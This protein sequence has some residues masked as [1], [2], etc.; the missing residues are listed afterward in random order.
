MK[1]NNPIGLL[2]LTSVQRDTFLP[3]P[4][5]GWTI[6]N[7]TNNRIES[8]DGVIWNG[9]DVH[10]TPTVVTL[11][12]LKASGGQTVL[13]GAAKIVYVFHAGETPS[14][15][16]IADAA[17]TGAWETITGADKYFSVGGDFKDKNGHT[18]T[19]TEV[20]GGDG[21]GG[22]VWVTQV[23][24]ALISLTVDTASVLMNTANAR[25]GN[26]RVATFSEGVPQDLTLTFP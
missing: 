3:T 10:I 5:I 2:H 24:Q 26:D 12:T 1:F 16:G 13:V 20:L 14:A 23:A 9:K 15:T 6:F 7:L 4:L 8:F 11:P 17:T 22:L 19:N 25:S 21:L 18:G